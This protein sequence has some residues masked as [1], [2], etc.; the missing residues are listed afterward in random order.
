M[1]KYL[2]ALRAHQADAQVGSLSIPHKA[3]Q[4]LSTTDR[5][6]YHTAYMT[7]STLI[8]PN[9]VS[10][11]RCTRLAMPEASTDSV[12]RAKKSSVSGSPIL[13]FRQT[14]YHSNLGPKVTKLYTCPK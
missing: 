1:S 6:F 3:T 13:Y 11:R 5:W 7:Y 12:L 2:T 9:T 14:C 4:Q 10:V 8:L